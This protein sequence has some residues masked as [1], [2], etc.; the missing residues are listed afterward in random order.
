MCF[1]P[2]SAIIYKDSIINLQ[3]YM[4]IFMFQS[5]SIKDQKTNKVNWDQTAKRFYPVVSHCLVAL[6]VERSE[7][8]RKWTTRFCAIF[9][10]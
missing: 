5:L 1:W 7:I 8:E 10:F 9:P 6:I 3:Y 2:F 4:T